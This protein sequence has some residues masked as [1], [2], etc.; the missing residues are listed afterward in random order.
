MRAL[1]LRVPERGG[2]LRRAWRSA[3][4]KKVCLFTGSANPALAASI[5]QYLETPIGK[6]RVMRFSDGESFV[7]FGENV[8]GVDAFV[9]QPTST[10]TND[11]V[12]ELLIMVDAL[13][14]GPSL[15]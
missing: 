14:P 7:E 9:V 2:S 15:P 5:G 10:P 3:V 8:R 11:N 13:R 4:F 1:R 6:C 12:M